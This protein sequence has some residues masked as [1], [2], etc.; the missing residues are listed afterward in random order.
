MPKPLLQAGAEPEEVA[1][2]ARAGLG[3]AGVGRQP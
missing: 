2:I 1:R 3:Q